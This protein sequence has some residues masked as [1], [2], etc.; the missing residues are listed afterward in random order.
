MSAADLKAAVA[1]ISTDVELAMV[2]ADFVATAVVRMLAEAL[3]RLHE[4]DRAKT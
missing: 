1:F 2:S 4:H 3:M